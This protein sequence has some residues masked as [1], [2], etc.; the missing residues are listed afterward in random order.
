VN[1]NRDERIQ[2]SI[3]GIEPADGARERMLANIRRK[4][5]E[6]ALRE[7]MAPEQ[8]EKAKLLPFKRITKWA[9]PIAAC[10]AIAV[11]G[12]AV[13]LNPSK[14][15]DPP[16]TG[17]DVQIPNPIV[18]IQDAEEFETRLGITADAPAGAEN[19]ICSIIDGNMADI[20][21][22]LEGRQYDLR[23]SKQSGDF[24]GIYATVIK[25]DTIDAS[26]DAVLT[27]YRSGDEIYLKITWTNGAATYILSNTD[28]ASADELKAVYEK[29]K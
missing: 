23:A 11:I 15:S 4:A 5:A 17:N 1:E 6:Q 18:D 7:D 14:P 20:V 3:N 19:V 2:E 26:T 25:E 16:N 21:F 28:G 9:L 12:A 8:P 22:D 13:I 10:F 29:V 27:T 24:S